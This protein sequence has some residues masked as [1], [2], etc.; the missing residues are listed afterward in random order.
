[1]E[2]G[3]RIDAENPLSWEVEDIPEIVRSQWRQIDMWILRDDG[4]R[5]DFSLLRPMEWVSRYDLVESGSI[6]LL[7]EELNIQGTGTVKSIRECPP[8]GQGKAS[9][10]T[11][12]FV[13]NQATNLGTL[14][15]TNG[16]R[17]TGTTIHPIWSIDRQ[18]FVHL[19]E[20]EAGEKVDSVS[21]PLTIE[22]VETERSVAD[23]FNIEVMGHHVYRVAEDG[24]LVHNPGGDD[25]ILCQ[26]AK[27]VADAVGIA[28][29]SGPVHHLA[30]NKNF[31]SSVRGGPWS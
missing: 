16:T 4:T 8:I 3:S 1:M 11:G 23:V 22:S 17:L 7:I 10:V 30:T 25:G 29:I 19:G 20:M 6:N 14:V 27:V 24:I 12:R 28:P 15:F 2:L 26:A 18:K 9:V 31:V 13:T 5:V 21:G